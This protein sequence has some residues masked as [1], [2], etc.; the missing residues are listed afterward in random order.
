MAYVKCHTNSCWLSHSKTLSHFN[1]QPQYLWNS[2]CSVSIIIILAERVQGIRIT[3]QFL[4]GFHTHGLSRVEVIVL[5]SH[6][7]ARVSHCEQLISNVN[8]TR[9]ESRPHLLFFWLFFLL[10]L[11]CMIICTYVV[12]LH[13]RSNYMNFSTHV[14]HGC[15]AI[16]HNVM[17][18]CMESIPNQQQHA[19]T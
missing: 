8:S 18:W 6:W 17:F 16:Y 19:T 13:L 3:A 15:E 11:F 2:Q 7:A 12:A 5:D 14:I 4:L 10:Q 1:C 9:L